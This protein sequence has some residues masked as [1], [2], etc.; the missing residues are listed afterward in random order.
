MDVADLI[1]K[2]AKE[3]AKDSIRLVKRCTK[4]DRKGA[5]NYRAAR[6]HENAQ[7]LRGRGRFEALLLRP[8]FSVRRVHEGCAAHRAGVRRH[9]VHRLL[10]EAYIVRRKVVGPLYFLD[11]DSERPRPASCSI[12]INNIIIGG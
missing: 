1:V 7:S 8:L 10:R 4:P 12:P 2:P 3:F 6:P 11:L 5:N 9:R